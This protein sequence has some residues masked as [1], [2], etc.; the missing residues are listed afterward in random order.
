MKERQS[1]TVVN[2]NRRRLLR[3]GLI[4]SGVLAVGPGLWGTT[5][6]ASPRSARPLS[7]RGKVS[8]IPNLAGTLHEVSVEND[9]DT[10][11][12]VPRGFS[13]R[14]VARTG[15]R[16]V[17][18]SDYVW[19]ADPD[20]GATFSM[21]DGGWVYVSNAE[22]GAFRQ[23][24]VGA[25]RF[26]ADGELVD[27]YSICTGTT[28]N[29]AGGP[30]PWGTWLTCEEIDEGLVYECDPTGRR[31][32]VPVPALGM[33]KHE[34]AAVDP[35]HRHV[36]LTEDVED[37]NFYRFV[38]EHYPEGGRADLSRG[39]LEVAVIDGDDPFQTR[40][41]EWQAIPNPVPR[42]GGNDPA[43][44]ELPTRKQVPEAAIFNGGE[45]CWYFDG[46]VYFTT[47]GDNRVWA[48]D[49]NRNTIDLVYDKHSDQ[50][51]NPGI[52][53]VDN[54]TVSAGGDVLVAEDGSEMRLVVVGPDVKPFE[55]VN[56]M[57]QRDSEIC[58]PAFNPSGERLYFSS[59]NGPA[60]NHADGR[61]Y[62]VHGPFF[63]DA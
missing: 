23:G 15:E 51:F 47:K 62:E 56:V 37:G 58:G 17:P 14:Q 4:A 60:G 7:M 41:V 27:S 52:D 26:G 18:A 9:P 21:D 54:L 57:G 28:N 59:Q 63:V 35:V 24:G 31:L 61:I 6:Q 12:L 32:A 22:V 2:Q 8:N 5:T 46:L 48:L 10:R 16:P 30:T 55:L 53:D 38:P 40:G 49:T 20:G 1:S 42:L 36:Y 11:M 33:F 44:R 25:L 3:Q 43:R 13:V 50:A 45:G 34:A 29:C 39:R 19:H